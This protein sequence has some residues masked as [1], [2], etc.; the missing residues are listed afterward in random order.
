MQVRKIVAIGALLCL[1]LAG[2][3]KLTWADDQSPAPPPPPAAADS[4]AQGAKDALAKLADIYAKANDLTYKSNLVVYGPPNPDGKPAQSETLFVSGAVEKPSSFSVKAYRANGTGKQ[5]PAEFFY[6]NGT[7]TYVFDTQTGLYDQVPTST[8]GLD[9]PDL[10]TT[11]IAEVADYATQYAGKM[12]FDEQPYDLSEAATVATDVQFSSRDQTIV[13][14][15]V[16]AITETYT[17]EHGVTTTLYVSLDKVT[18]LP[19]RVRQDRTANGQTNT[20][21]QEDFTNI[22]V[23]STPDDL[24]T[25]MWTPPNGTVV[26][27]TPPASSAS[28]GS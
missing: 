7:N 5:K 2:G 18:D 28:G 9:I 26:T 10:H 27:W 1:G 24:G 15:P 14:Q 19:R 17:D 8:D 25:F 16:L 3:G 6:G 12:F 11:G 20:V 4:G 23:G 22:H 13:N 21:F